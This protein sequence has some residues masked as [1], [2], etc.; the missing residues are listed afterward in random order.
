M[1]AL[2]AEMSAALRCT[3][4]MMRRAIS[5]EVEASLELT[6]IVAASVILC[7]QAV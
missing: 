4:Q 3:V 2:R 7:T 6:V 1:L 5:G